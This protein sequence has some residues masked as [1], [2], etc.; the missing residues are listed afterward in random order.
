MICPLSYTGT[1]MTTRISNYCGRY[2]CAKFGK[3]RREETR[4]GTTPTSLVRPLVQKIQTQIQA[5]KGASTV[6]RVHRCIAIES[7]KSIHSYAV[8]HDVCHSRV[9]GS[10]KH[11][12]RRQRGCVLLQHSRAAIYCCTLPKFQ[13]AAALPPVL[14]LTIQPRSPPYS[15]V[16]CP[17]Q[18]RQLTDTPSGSDSGKFL[19]MLSQF[20]D[21]RPRLPS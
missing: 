8:E 5:K 4:A 21:G 11:S 15:A 9:K 19:R 12:T 2:A 6:C 17:P 20:R 3:Q 16:P 7:L 10:S 18:G 14:A 1:R 13:V